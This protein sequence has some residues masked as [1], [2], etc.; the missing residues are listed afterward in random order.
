M[1]VLVKKPISSHQCLWLSNHCVHSGMEYVQAAV[2]QKD[3]RCTVESWR[4]VTV[5]F[6]MHSVFAEESAA[7]ALLTTQGRTIA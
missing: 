4:L 7:Y 1:E 3:L 5:I 6:G 2:V